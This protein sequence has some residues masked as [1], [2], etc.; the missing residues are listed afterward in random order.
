MAK[1]LV[2]PSDWGLGHATRCIPIIHHLRNRG[3][4]VLIGGN[5]S[6]LELPAEE[7]PGTPII[8]LPR[9]AVS[10]TR[11]PFLLALKFPFLVAKVYATAS[12]ER[13]VIDK[14]VG[15]EAIDAIISD[16]RFGCFHHSCR[17][18]YISHQ[19]CV[20][21][22]SGFAWLEA[23][24]SSKL[25]KA[26][27]QFDALWIPDIPGDENLTGD[28]SR[29]YPLPKNHRFVGPLSRFSMHT[30]QPSNP[31]ELLIMLS[32]PEPQRTMFEQLAIRQL[33]N[34]DGSVTI[35]RGKAS[36]HPKTP[37]PNNIQ[38]V[39]HLPTAQFAARIR[40]ANAIVCRGGYSTIMDLVA[41]NRTAVLVPTPGQTEQ[42]YLCNR[43]QEMN[44]FLSK[45]QKTFDLLSSLE[46][47]KKFSASPFPESRTLL[48]DALDTA[49]S[50]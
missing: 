6:S 22:P 32:G 12:R 8:R 7:F 9:Y 21:M 13:S 42:E 10:Y 5:G 48:C 39:P 35:V 20:K 15:Q 18:I 11:S 31:C 41:L 4:E 43:M 16:Q 27:R 26:A 46:D 29:A 17:S 49:L 1:V 30:A 25:R 50:S 24:V 14:F 38:L 19:L 28:L 40:G 2:A 23:L 44:W 37:V 34:F 33:R 45:Q 36:V 3:H 47:L